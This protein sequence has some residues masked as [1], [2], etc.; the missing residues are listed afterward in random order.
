[1]DPSQFNSAELAAGRL[2]Q[3]MLEAAKVA[4][5]IVAV[6]LRHGLA[7]DG[8]AGA[9]TQ[10]VL[11]ALV[12]GRTPIPTGREGVANVY[13]KF[14]Y[15]EG[16]GGRINVEAPWTAANIVTVTLHTGAKVRLHK[17]VAAEFVQLYKRAS[18]VSGY[19]P[20][21]V[22]TYVPR[23]TLWDPNRTLSLHSW[24]IAID[25]DPSA[26]PMGGANS[27][28]RTQ[29]GQQFVQVFRDA[30]WTWGGDWPMKDDMHF[31]RAYA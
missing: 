21:S 1:M 16:G 18:E 10:A 4:G 15:T 9:R 11:Q 17:L 14:A 2:T 3:A 13:G 8:K 22:Q 25:F 27:R 7:P 12:E 6:Q 29:A 30:G 28:L 24:G 26:N 31:Q 23:H 5:G 19:T 20:S